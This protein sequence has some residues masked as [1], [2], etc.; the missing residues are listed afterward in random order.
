MKKKTA[1]D[2]AREKVV[3]M[4]LLREDVDFFEYCT[5]DGRF[6]KR[7]AQDFGLTRRETH[8]ILNGPVA[9]SLLDIAHLDGCVFA[10][11]TEKGTELAKQLF[12]ASL[13][14]DSE[15]STEEEPVAKVGQNEI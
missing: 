1:L 6:F 10:A 8:K 2:R 14:F 11:L 5:I 3:L 4:D 13:G 12:N 15:E 9:D 7:Y